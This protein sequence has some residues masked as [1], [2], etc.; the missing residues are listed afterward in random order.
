MRT[1]NAKPITAA[2]SRHMAWVKEQ[3]C[4][5]CDKTGPSEAHHF[6]QGLHFTTIPLC[7]SCHRDGFNG[8]HGQARI[9]KALKKTELSCLNETI[10]RMAN[11]RV[12]GP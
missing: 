9:W 10:A 7:P 3:P 11:V 4:A 8:I 12:E 6:A 1:K 5:V 2:E